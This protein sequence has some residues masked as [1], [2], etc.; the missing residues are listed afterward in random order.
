MLSSK[1]R[2]NLQKTR[3]GLD[4]PLPCKC[5]S[6][7]YPHSLPLLLDLLCVPTPSPLFHPLIPYT[8]QNLTAPYTAVEHNSFHII[9]MT[10]L[11][12][13]ATSS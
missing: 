11:R 12:K 5:P 13:S 4:L 7:P 6:L 10:H 9:T 3:R 8:K 2:C 1:N